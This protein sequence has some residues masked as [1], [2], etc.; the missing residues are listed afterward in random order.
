MTTAA[1]AKIKC[2]E[3]LSWNTLAQVCRLCLR[4]QCIKFDIFEDEEDSN[5]TAT[6][7]H[8]SLHERIS[9]FYD[10]QVGQLTP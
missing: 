9:R 4:N 2:P 7:A 3:A 8:S 10:I 6:F 5:S 1:L